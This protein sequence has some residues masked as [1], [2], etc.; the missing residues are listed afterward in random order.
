MTIIPDSNFMLKF[1]A[2]TSVNGKMVGVGEWVKYSGKAV[3]RALP[4]LA[5]AAL[6]FSVS[7]FAACGL[8]VVYFFLEAR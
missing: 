1:A 5:G 6:W 4:S 3:G 2:I 8:G 7:T